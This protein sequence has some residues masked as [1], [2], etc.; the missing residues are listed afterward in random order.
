MKIPIFASNQVL[1]YC[2]F[3]ESHC[4]SVIN[5]VVLIQPEL[6][7]FNSYNLILPATP[8]PSQIS[9]KIGNNATG[10]FFKFI[11]L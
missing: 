4:I 11:I 10:I 9:L 7:Y 8:K 2:A 6:Y 3:K 1:G 5:I